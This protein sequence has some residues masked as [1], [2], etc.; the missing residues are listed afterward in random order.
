MK[1]TE[2]VISISDAIVDGNRVEHMGVLVLA[3]VEDKVRIML[4]YTDENNR[5]S[6]GLLEVDCNGNGYVKMFCCPEK[7]CFGFIDF[8]KDPLKSRS[9][10][11]HVAKY[12]DEPKSNELDYFFKILQDYWSKFTI[13]MIESKVELKTFLEENNLENI[14]NVMKGVWDPSLLKMNNPRKFSP[15][16]YK[17]ERDCMSWCG[18]TYR[19]YLRSYVYFIQQN[20]YNINKS[21]GKKIIQSTTN[22]VKFVKS[23]G[24]TDEVMLLK[25]L[26]MF[27]RRHSC[28]GPG[29]ESFSYLRC[30]S[31]HSAHE[32]SYEELLLLTDWCSVF[33]DKQ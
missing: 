10:I 17:D 3:Q 21:E 24:W 32:L 20:D 22:V 27:L 31:C 8:K 33:L 9:I 4:M 5:S 1:V 30:K 25:A 15:C 16:Y 13:L 18:K 11:V 28:E 26:V 7:S 2:E 14:K 23:L 6:S 29:C 19:K 12:D